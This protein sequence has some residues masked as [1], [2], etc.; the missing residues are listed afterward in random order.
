MKP[1]QTEEKGEDARLRAR[2]REEE[3]RVRRLEMEQRKAETKKRVEDAIDRRL[4]PGFWGRYGEYTGYALLA[5]IFLFVLISNFAGD[6]RKLSDISVN[7]EAFITSHNEGDSSYK[8]GRNSF[9][10]GLTLAKAKEFFRNQLTT[11]KSM[12]RCNIK[13]LDHVTVKDSYNFYKEH[14]ECHFEETARNCSSAYAEIPMSV[15]RN[16]NCLRNK[17]EDFKPS[18]DFTIRCNTNKSNGC[19]G[20][21]LIH[22]LNFLRK[23]FVSEDCWTSTM[24]EDK[25]TECPALDKFKSCEKRFVGTHC[26]LEGEE[27]IKK[28]LQANGPVISILLPFRDLLIYRSG[29]YVVEDRS[30]LD[31]LAIVKIVGWETLP[32][33]NGVWLLET[34][35]GKDWG[36]DGIARVRIGSEESTIEKFAY[37]LYP[38]KTEKTGDD[39]RDRSEEAQK[40]EEKLGTESDQPFE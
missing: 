37:I 3:E 39:E 4:T 21:Y 1:E 7:E 26:A 33:G 25:G 27:E 32:D 24:G 10:E 22:T 40:S 9:F 12:P 5:G 11:K 34:L 15:F 8:L 16:R 20:G 18:V 14:P 35:W 30:K 6:R 19:N 38:E 36:T 2:R 23:G 13:S 29:D 17:N 28:E 31:G